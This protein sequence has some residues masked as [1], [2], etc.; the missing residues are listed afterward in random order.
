[1]RYSHPWQ[2]RAAHDFLLA[3]I[4]STVIALKELL[5]T[6]EE[7]HDIVTNLRHEKIIAAK[8]FTFHQLLLV[9]VL[10]NRA[11]VLLH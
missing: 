7:I 6:L 3:A 9:Y 4:E 8:W 2:I 5:M 10:S 11:Q 1:L